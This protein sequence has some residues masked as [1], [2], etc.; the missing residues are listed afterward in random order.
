MAP[1]KNEKSAAG[2][3]GRVAGFGGLL[4]LTRGAPFAQPTG[5]CINWCLFTHTLPTCPCGIQM[6]TMASV[7]DPPPMIPMT[8]RPFFNTRKLQH[9]I[10]ARAPE[11]TCAI[12]HLSWFR[13]IAR[14]SNLV[15]DYGDFWNVHEGCPPWS[16]FRAA[17]ATSTQDEPHTLRIDQSSLL[18][19]YC[20]PPSSRATR[21]RSP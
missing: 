16:S 20:Y 8:Y 3:N 5:C 1:S 13:Q 17:D 12:L 14:Q 9:W 18:T 19:P 21:E 2:I 11:F 10:Q 6:V 15:L 7:T 4:E